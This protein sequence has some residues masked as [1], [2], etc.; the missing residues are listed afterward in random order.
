M[1]DI[2][3]SNAAYLEKIIRAMS[4]QKVA[5]LEYKLARKEVYLNSANLSAAFQR[6]LSEPKNKQTSR[7]Q[8]QQFVVLNHILFSN[9][10]TIAQSISRER[11]IYPPDLV[12]LAKKTYA[13]LNNSYKKLGS[14]QDL[15]RLVETSNDNGTP[16]PDD[17]LMKEQ[18]SFI[19]NVSRDIE[20]LSHQILL[21]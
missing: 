2:V 21:A 17:A 14:E 13:K 8:L 19:H 7:S 11:G 16:R 18:L 9:V 12:L 10:A 4:G 3:R 6:M 5:E 20:K 15:D 1:R